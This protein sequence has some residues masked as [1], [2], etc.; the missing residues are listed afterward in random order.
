MLNKPVFPFMK[1]SIHVLAVAPKVAAMVNLLLKPPKKL[2]GLKTKMYLLAI[3][4]VIY[5]QLQLII[6]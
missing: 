5:F 4:R 1:R 6:T 2:I 3:N